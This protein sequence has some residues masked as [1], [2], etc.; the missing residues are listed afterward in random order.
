MEV[1]DYA[2]ELVALPVLKGKTMDCASTLLHLGERVR[3]RRK[4]GGTTLTEDDDHD[5]VP[6]VRPTSGANLGFGGSSRHAQKSVLQ[7][8]LFPGFGQKSHP[9]ECNIHVAVSESNVFFNT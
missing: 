7:I 9:V 8:R 3:L 4:F 5:K 2:L 1:S 6:I